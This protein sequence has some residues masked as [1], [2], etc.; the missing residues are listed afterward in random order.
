MLSTH[1]ACDDDNLNKVLSFHKGQD[2]TVGPEL[3]EVFIR[4]GWAEDTKKKK[5]ETEK[6][7]KAK[8][9]KSLSGPKENK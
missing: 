3:Y 6:A 4:E 9:D 8:E 1:R 2:Y 7:D 5:G